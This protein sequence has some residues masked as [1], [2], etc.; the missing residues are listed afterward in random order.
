MYRECSNC[1]YGRG[2]GSDVWCG[3]DPK[4]KETYMAKKRY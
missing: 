3:H 4:G 1:E 2:I